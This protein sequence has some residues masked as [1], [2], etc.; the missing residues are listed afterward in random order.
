MAPEI[1]HS[2]P[3][4]KRSDIYALRIMLYELAI[5]TAP[6]VGKN[7]TFVAVK[8]IKELPLRPHLV[9]PMLPQS[10]E[11]VILKAIAKDPSERFQTVTEFNASLQAVE[12]IEHKND[13]PL[14]LSNLIDV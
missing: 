1:V 5:G 7:P 2:K 12:A 9:N 3:T 13:K 6:F 14:K 8:H 11:N 10:L 4:T